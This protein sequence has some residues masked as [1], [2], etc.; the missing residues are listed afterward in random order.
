MADGDRNDTL[1]TTDGALATTA[2]AAPGDGGADPALARR[3]IGRYELVRSL[4]A[5]GM[6]VVWEAIDPELGRRVAIKLMREERSARLAER[7]K[8]EAQALAQLHHPNVVAVYDVGLDDG[9]LYLVMQLVVGATI[10]RVLEASTLTRGEIVALVAQAGRGLAAAHRA[11]IVHR[12]FKPSNVLVD[13]DGV[14]RVSDFGLARASDAGGG[15]AGGVAD[16]SLDA[17]I[18]R[19]D[20]VGTPAYMAP[21][22]FL[23]GPI[24]AATDQFAFCVTLWEALA[25]ERP[26]AGAS[27][28]EV[29]EA[30]IA[31]RMRE[32]PARIPRRARS[33]L[34]R[35]SRAR[36][37]IGSRRWTSC[38]PSSRPTAGCCGS[39]A[40]SGSR[41]SPRR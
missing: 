4:G 12:D 9:E 8:R 40:A 10:D 21:E 35:G 24:T 6:G 13:G 27:V 7:M 5:G 22:Q 38:S 32:L 25:G 41:R 11:G 14:A 1:L 37:R 3:R 31:G 16:G 34:L 28:D 17:S 36:R 29:R 18:T 15:G 33:V 19:G 20:L 2:L 39:P 26:F 23:G 30:V